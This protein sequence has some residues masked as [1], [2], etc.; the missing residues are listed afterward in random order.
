M[1]SDRVVEGGTAL[2]K[3]LFVDDFDTPLECVN[4]EPGPRVTL[5]DSNKDVISE[6]YALPS[7]T[8]DPGTWAANL[9]IPELGL[10]EPVELTIIWKFR[11][12]EGALHKST[13][14]LIIVPAT[15]HRITD[16]TVI[17]DVD[18][19]FDVIIPLVYD[20]PG[21]DTL[22]FSLFLNNE[23]RYSAPIPAT[24]ASV[25][26]H[27]GLDQTVATL[28][29]GG[30]PDPSLEP[31]ILFANYK[32]LGANAVRYD[33]KVW[34]VTP[35][36]MVAASLLEDWINKARVENVIPQLEYT[37]SDLMSYLLRGLA[38]F[39]AYGS[40]ITAFNGTNMQG[41]IL[42]GW[43]VMASYYALGAQLQAE[44]ALAFD[45]S[46]QTV[47]LNV[48]RTPSIESALGRIESQM[49]NAVKPL[50]KL[51]ARYGITSGSGAQG[52]QP[53]S[54]ARALGSLQILN[55]PTSRLGY[56][57]FQYNSRLRRY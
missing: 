33:Y 5:L 17:K 24:D 32:K 30:F 48:D 13:Q 18:T 53:M 12:E 41:P 38:L 3:E 25:S 51:L 45:F 46:G 22:T 10:T 31:M 2:V 56:T 6:V 23:M 37:Q 27:Q 50:K 57:N 55:A 4:T 42:D 14:R 52:G 28:S 19:N 20:Q 36:I 47:N 34:F 15:E 1:C 40:Q 16:V 9:P 11:D 8:D 43:L 39:N 49:E 21:G 26:L 7:V 35:Q 29:L 44:G 54:G